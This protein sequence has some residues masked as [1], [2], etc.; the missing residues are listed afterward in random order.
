MKEPSPSWIISRPFRY[1]PRRGLS[2]PA[3]TVLDTSGRVIEDEQRAVF[4]Y[5]A[6]QGL[7]ADIIFGVGT[8]GEWNRIS[9]SERQ[10]LIR[11][12]VNEIARINQEVAL[13]ELRPVEAW[14]GVTAA[15]RA[16]TLANLE[17]ALEARA[18]AAVI[19]PLSIGD[20]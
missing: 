5:V 7:G 19:A 4:R 16:E 8:T 1:Q 3:I 14:V 9:N 18:D 10:R 17:Y 20:L 15:T 11:I 6:Q 2:I 13:R 12:E